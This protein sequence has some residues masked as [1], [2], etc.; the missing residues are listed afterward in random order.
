MTQDGAPEVTALAGRAAADLSRLVPALRTG[1][2]PPDRDLA[3]TRLYEALHDL[4][5]NLA[6]QGPLLVGVEDL[7]WADAG[8]LAATSY[9]L[10]A[11]RDE[12]V[13]IVATFRS[14][15]V[16][17]THPLRRWLAEVG[18]DAD[19]ERVE[20]EPL[21]EAEVGSL[22]EHLIGE[23]PRP[24]EAE[25]IHRRSDGN[26]FF[27]EEL[28][29][30]RVAGPARLPASLRDVLAARVD[31]LPEGARSLIATAAV[32]GREV[33]HDI[34]VAVVGG[35][36]T[37]IS[38]DL[39]A[40]VEAG[41]LTPT[42]AAD[43]DDAYSFR[44]ALLHEAVYD[45]MLPTE[46][47]RLH[48]S[49][50]EYLSAHQVRDAGP[51]HLVQIAHHWREGRDERA[52]AASI[53][54]GDAAMAAFSYDIAADEFESAL[55]LWEDDAEVGPRPRRLARTVLPRGLPQLGLSPRG[56]RLPRGHR[57]ARRG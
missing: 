8:T 26:P 43:G 51:A 2:A 37:A 33:E 11:I 41:L 15:D 53:A 7:H 54:A 13:A 21:D 10:R 38:S 19:V 9:L 57:R 20:L 46:R 16:T 25:S 1:D 42:R 28:V 39:A 22:V 32:G 5:R 40:L 49:W 6:G 3:Q 18:R 44:H 36:E 47:R 29:C 30:C 35:D 24:G 50:G 45:A 17:R 27:V 14:D 52:L 12:P 55:L 4:I 31:A 23:R 56:R 34:L 48:R